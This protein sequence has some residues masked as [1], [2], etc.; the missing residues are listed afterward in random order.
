M[1]M[2]DK[3]ISQLHAKVLDA[4]REIDCEVGGTEL[5][6][7]PVNVARLLVRLKRRI[8]DADAASRSD[9]A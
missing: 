2:A 5:A 1:N 8:Q 6:Q 7:M 3:G 4:A 9:E